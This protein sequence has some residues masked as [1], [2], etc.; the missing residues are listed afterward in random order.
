MIDMWSTPKSQLL[1]PWVRV[2]KLTPSAI[3]SSH[4]DWHLPGVEG[5]DPVRREPEIHLWSGEK[6]CLYP[7]SLEKAE[8]QLH[9]L[10]MIEVS[11]LGKRELTQD[12]E[13]QLTAPAQ[14]LA[15]VFPESCI[16]LTGVGFHF[17]KC[18]A[19][20]PF[21]LLISAPWNLQEK[22]PRFCWFK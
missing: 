7:G 20:F 18:W 5:V 21:E 4:R 17:R 6:G 22:P 1:S 13:A 12:R 19:Y 2:D 8:K 9:L 16:L 15:A 14:V 10:C 11:T 3:S